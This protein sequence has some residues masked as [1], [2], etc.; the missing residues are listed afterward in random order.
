MTREKENGFSLIEV[1]IS[2]GLISYCLLA[3][4]GLLTLGLNSMHSGKENV[5]AIHTLDRISDQS[6]IVEQTMF[7]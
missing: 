7:F 1:V 5:S 4:V 3:L 2:L 6:Q